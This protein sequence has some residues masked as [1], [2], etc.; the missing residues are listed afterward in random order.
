MTNNCDSLISLTVASIYFKEYFITLTNHESNWFNRFDGP[1]K[2]FI[3]EWMCDSWSVKYSQ[4]CMNELHCTVCENY[5]LE[6]N[7]NSRRGSSDHSIW[8]RALFIV[9]DTKAVHLQTD[10]TYVPNCRHCNWCMVYIRKLSFA[11]GICKKLNLHPLEFRLTFQS[12]HVE[13]DLQ[14]QLGVSVIKGYSFKW[15][16]LCIISQVSII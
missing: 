15:H 10:S 11:T 7:F 5:T 6:Q 12:T 2:S 16:R 3:H 14:V 1:P 4:L 8:P 13:D 9:I